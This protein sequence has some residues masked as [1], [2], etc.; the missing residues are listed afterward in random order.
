MSTA[1]AQPVPLGT[2]TTT[3][4]FPIPTSYFSVALG[5]SALGLSWRYGATANLVPSW[6]GERYTGAR[7]GNL[8]GTDHSVPS[9]L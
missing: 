2:P 7:L 5:T 6:V 4:P 8:A 3:K 1:A 9:N